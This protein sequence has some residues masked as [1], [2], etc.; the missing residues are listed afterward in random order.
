MIP[1]RNGGLYLKEAINS[2]LSQKF[3][4]YELI[5]SDDNSTDNSREYLKTLKH[6]NVK[7]LFPEPGMSMSEH[8]DYV[9]SK[10]IG[11]WQIFLGQDDGLQPYFFEHAEYLT[12]L[13]NKKNIRTIMSSR[14][15][16]FW[17][18]VEDTYGEIA[19]AYNAIPKEITLN[20][21]KE[22]LK[23]LL[24]LQTYFELPEAYTTSI[25]SKSIFDEARKRQNG[26][27]LLSHPQDANLA[28]IACS[29]EKIYLKTFI[30]LGWVGS[31]PKS[32]GL[33]I[34]NEKKELSEL[35][36]DYLQKIKNSKITY[37]CDF[38]DFSFGS[39]AAYLW[40]AFIQTPTLRP[41]KVNRI[42]ESVLFKSLVLGGIRNYVKN[43][44]CSNHTKEKEFLDI[45]KNNRCSLILISII[46]FF[47]K[48][49]SFIDKNVQRIR[50]KFYKFIYCAQ[51]IHIKQSEFLGKSLN[52][53][54][55]LSMQCY[56]NIK[57]L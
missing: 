16:F 45:V 51:N 29:L 43:L 21:K 55:N 13:A 37:R 5:I 12:D 7:V 47:L 30:P 2:V 14:A 40:Q 23:A 11:L 57:K 26:K 41:Q 42:L 15:Y 35:R 50:N 31:S 24:G 10:S 20:F 36:S 32:A 1:A 46:S 34:T 3:K 22:T 49:I 6:P 53:A 27:L 56:L 48:F 28:A 18:G 39:D 8:W 44:K 4:D 38:G 52:D 54:S 9:Q 25:F 17:P 19:V 33:A